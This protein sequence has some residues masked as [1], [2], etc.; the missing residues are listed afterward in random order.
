MVAFIFY[1]KGGTAMKKRSLFNLA[2]VFICAFFLAISVFTMTQKA[3]AYKSENMPSGT[4]HIG[5]LYNSD[6]KFDIN[7]LNALAK[8]ANFTDVYE[9]IE[10]AEQGKLKT[11]QN[12]GDVVVDFGK[13]NNR[14]L[15]WI[16]V[17]LSNS[18]EGA[19]LT[20]WLAGKESANSSSTS[21]QEVSTWSD[22]T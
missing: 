13:Y 2:L 12:F 9:M 3:Y 11:S 7:N 1:F 6:G 20:L 16:P 21:K 5:N 10:Y 4:N 14:K 15:T 17:Y 8:K 22:G 19:I 18:D